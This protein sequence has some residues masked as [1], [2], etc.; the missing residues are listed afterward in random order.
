MIH[1]EQSMRVIHLPA[2][3]IVLKPDMVD[4]VQVRQSLQLAM[5]IGDTDGANVIA[6]GEQQLQDHSPII[7]EPFR[8]GFDLHPFA[9][10][11][12][13]GGKELRCAGKFD[14]AKPACADIMNAIQVTE[15]WNLQPSLFRRLQDSCAI[16][17]ADLIAVNGECL[18]CHKKLFR[19]C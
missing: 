11:R 8:V 2:R 15:C 12:R 19:A 13:A 3:K 16:R 9:D 1:S 14:E 5:A 7:T 10:P 18:C 6:L 4:T 17:S